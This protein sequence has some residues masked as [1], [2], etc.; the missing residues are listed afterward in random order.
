MNIK[1]YR[2]VETKEDGII[3]ETKEDE[4]CIFDGREKRH[5]S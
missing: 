5:V 4:K 1:P 3:V 2:A